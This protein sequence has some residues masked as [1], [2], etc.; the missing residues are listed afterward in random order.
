MKKI[1]ILIA[2]LLLTA[3]VPLYPS[4]FVPAK[5]TKG[6]QFWIK[7]IDEQLA[8]IK[9]NIPENSKNFTLMYLPVLTEKLKQLSEFQRTAQT[10][11]SIEPDLNAYRYLVKTLQQNPRATRDQFIDMVTQARNAV[12]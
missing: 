12:Q 11:R 9:Q 8:W 10:I 7:K 6:N 3:T 2:A 4:E 5:T 1:M